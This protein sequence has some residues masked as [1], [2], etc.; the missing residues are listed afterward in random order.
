MLIELHQV[1]HTKK[2]WIN[3]NLLYEELIAN[4]NKIY[5]GYTTNIK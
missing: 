2:R 4:T 1:L 3:K 5:R